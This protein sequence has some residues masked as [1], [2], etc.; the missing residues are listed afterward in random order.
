LAKRF[1]II[2]G[3]KEAG[4]LLTTPQERELQRL[5][6]RLFLEGKITQQELDE[7]SQKA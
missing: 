3:N 5:G 1:L 6:K 2:L 4:Q 7:V